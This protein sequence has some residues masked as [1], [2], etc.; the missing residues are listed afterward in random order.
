[1]EDVEPELRKQNKILNIDYLIER[2]KDFINRLY[3]ILYSEAFRYN[4]LNGW[5]QSL[6]GSDK[7]LIER[8]KLVRVALRNAQVH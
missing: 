8:K 1:M 5:Y 4:E 3:P 6:C 7:N 2:M